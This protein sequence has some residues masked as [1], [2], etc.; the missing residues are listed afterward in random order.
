MRN[1][2]KLAVF[3]IGGLC[4]IATGCLQQM[5]RPTPKVTSKPGPTVEQAQY[6]PSWGPKKRIAVMGFDNKTS[7][8]SGGQFDIGSGMTDQLNT[9]LFQTGAFIVLERQAIQDLMREQEFGASGRVKHQTAAKIGEIEGAELLIYGAITEYD[10]AQAEAGGGVGIGTT[11]GSYLGI[12]GLIFGAA[13]DAA[14][15]AATARQAHVAID[16]RIVDANT[17]RVVNATSVEG[18]PRE[19]GGEFGVSLA[20]VAFGSS[21]YYKTPIGQAVRDCINTAVNFVVETAFPMKSQTK[22]V[23]LP[24][25]P[26]IYMAVDTKEPKPEPEPVKEICK[27][28]NC[29]LANIREGPGSEYRI[30]ATVKKGTELE[31]VETSGGWVK[32][33]MEDE[34]IG[35]IFGKLVE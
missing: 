1:I 4:F 19:V 9:A 21:A 13:A 28:A 16:I 11:L 18:K 10:P 35:W 25:A 7:Y 30:I 24:T 34:R 31:K 14:G 33:K 27:V 23:M 20:N 32:V 2:S 17:G 29:S 5:T 15:A 22:A 6:E 3:L 8:T 12:G 26:E